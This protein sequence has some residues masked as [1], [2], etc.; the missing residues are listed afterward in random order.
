[1][2]VNKALLFLLTTG[3]LMS[4]HAACDVESIVVC[5]IKGSNEDCKTRF[6]NLI[7]RGEPCGPVDIKVRF[8]IKNNEDVPI[9][10]RQEPE[11]TVAKFKLQNQVIDKTPLEAQGSRQG[12]RYDFSIDTCETNLLRASLKV[13]GWIQGEVG[14]NGSY[15]YGWDFVEIKTGTYAPTTTPTN[16]P[17]RAPVIGVSPPPPPPPP[18][19]SAPTNAPVAVAPPPPPPDAPSI[20]VSIDCFVAGPDGLFNTR[21]ENMAPVTSRGDCRQTFRYEYKVTNLS[22]FIV[23]LQGLVMQH[24]GGGQQALDLGGNVELAASL[25]FSIPE[26]EKDID[27]CTYSGETIPSG[28]VAIGANPNGGQSVSDSDTYVVTLP[29][30]PFLWEMEEAV[31]CF[32]VENGVQTTTTCN[33]Y[34]SSISSLDQC[35]V[36][37]VYKYTITNVGLSCETVDHVG[38]SIGA[39]TSMTLALDSDYSGANRIF[40]PEDSWNL[41]DYRTI[42]IC[43]E[44]GTA[45]NFDLALNDGTTQR[46][47]Y[48][49]I[50]VTLPAPEPCPEPGPAPGPPPADGVECTDRPTE[51][52]FEFTGGNCE[53]STTTLGSARKLRSLSHKSGSYFTCTNT[54]SGNDITNPS[55]IVIKG[56]R[57]DVY[58]EDNVSLGSIITATPPDGGDV[59]SYMDVFIYTTDGVET[60]TFNFHSSC[61]KPIYTGDI[62]GALTLVGYKNEE[63]GT[64]GRSE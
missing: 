56:K 50:A 58:F 3:R 35:F 61:S 15:C 46:G 9:V 47:T 18:L 12:D 34:I 48:T 60:Q 21:C 36:D 5:K 41:N 24:S 25:S 64:V 37:V 7:A 13:E 55:K 42:N 52:S 33:D 43:D 23:L 31:E 44:V 11:Q 32:I 45:E 14:M 59:D 30:L 19:T 39:S 62:F 57:G 16:T 22:D 10:F 20:S 63:Q 27:V 53:D 1:M 40:C 4:G 49:Y 54:N 28:I 38:A 2:I 17:T 6:D 51:M 29:D 8:N 26:D